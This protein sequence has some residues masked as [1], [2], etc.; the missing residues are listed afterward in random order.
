[1]AIDF[2]LIHPFWGY[3]YQLGCHIL[4]DFYN[5]CLWLSNDFEQSGVEPKSVRSPFAACLFGNRRRGTFVP[6]KPCWMGTCWISGF[7][8]CDPKIDSLV[9]I[10][11]SR[12]SGQNIVKLFFCIQASLDSKTLCPLVLRSSAT[13]D[14]RVLFDCLLQ[15][16]HARLQPFQI[17]ANPSRNNFQHTGWSF[18]HLTCTGCKWAVEKH[19][20]ATFCWLKVQLNLEK[21]TRISTTWYLWV[22]QQ[23]KLYMVVVILVRTPSV[24]SVACIALCRSSQSN[25]EWDST[26]LEVGI[27]HC[28]CVRVWTTVVAGKVTGQISPMS[29][30]VCLITFCTLPYCRNR[31][32]LKKGGFTVSHHNCKLHLEGVRAIEKRASQP[33]AQKENGFVTVP[34]KTGDE[35]R[36][37]I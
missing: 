4:Y 27:W 17:T 15:P 32:G 12:F 9:G 1:M 5:A 2:F 30:Q 13:N 24:F 23:S 36:R 29:W 11:P 25:K 10:Y 18:N 19:G 6:S 31:K 21:K 8:W 3:L 28:R 33:M 37:C 7:R 22:W 26:N 35:N 14:T 16:F 34:F 20:S